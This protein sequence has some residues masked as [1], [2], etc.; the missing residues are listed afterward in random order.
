MSSHTTVLAALHQL[1]GMRWQNFNRIVQSRLFEHPFNTWRRTDLLTAEI[2]DD[3]AIEILSQLPRIQ[4]DEVQKKLEAHEV[5]VITI[6]DTGYPE[7]L[8]HIAS[9]P[10]VLY[11]R[12]NLQA[13]TRLSLAV[14]G[15]RR[16]T[17]Y[18]LAVV[19]RLIRPLARSGVTIVSGLAFGVD[20]AVHRATLHEHGQT[21][22]VLGTGI[23]LTYPWDHHDLVKHII[24]SRGAIVTEFPL[25]AG[26][27]RHHFPQRNRIISGLSK[28]TLLI[29][30]GQRSGALITA[31][32]ALD[33]NRDVLAVPGS[34]LSEQS[35]G[36]NS[37]LSL[38]A[39]A[40]TSAED[41]L[42][43]LTGA[44]V[45]QLPLNP[46]PKP[47]TP[48]EEKLMQ[49]LGPEPV[50]VDELVE[51]SRLDTSR[52]TAT[53]AL[54]EIYGSVRHLGGMYYCLGTS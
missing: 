29:E 36:V 49:L 54:M 31:K 10:P 9:P 21:V 22:A 47:R 27:L 52:V 35:V 4:F 33:Q 26:P 1:S 38:G 6:H 51:K 18:G 46:V 45:Q 7:L 40:V 13:L 5:Q 20:A 53:L 25:G 37:W 28:A 41:I 11:L 44:I 12:G 17:P 30:A 43:V 42:S 16:P 39:K 32:F 23:D 8:K 14:V 24:Q 48:D 3:H 19:D 50:H 2:P 15:T 34:I